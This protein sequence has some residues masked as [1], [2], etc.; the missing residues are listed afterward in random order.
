MSFPAEGLET[1]FK[2][3]IDDVRAFLESR[4][5][6]A[7]AVYNCSERKYNKSKFDNRVRVHTSLLS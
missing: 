2:N 5:A 6:G 4:H 3:H 1:A 7:Y